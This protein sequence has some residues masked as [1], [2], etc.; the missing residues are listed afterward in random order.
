V[1]FTLK[2]TPDGIKLFSENNAHTT[3]YTDYITEIHS[4]LYIYRDSLILEP[5]EHDTILEVPLIAQ[6]ADK[7]FWAAA[8]LSVLGYQRYEDVTNCQVMEVARTLGVIVGANQNCCEDP[9]SCNETI[10]INGA[11]KLY[12]YFDLAKIR[13]DSMISV[14][15]IQRSLNVYGPIWIGTTN[16]ANAISNTLVIHGIKD[17]ILYIM[18]P[19][20]GAF[21]T[22]HY[23]EL[24]ANAYGKWAY[25]LVPRF[26]RLGGISF[27]APAQNVEYINPVQFGFN[28][29]TAMTGYQ[30]RL[31]Q[32]GAVAKDTSAETKGKTLIELAKGESYKATARG[33]KMYTA[34]YV[35]RKF[36]TWTKDTIDFTVSSTVDAN[37]DNAMHLRIYPN[38]AA[39]SL[40]ISSNLNTIAARFEM[41]DLLGNAVQSGQVNSNGNTT[42]DLS[43]QTAGTYLLI[44]RDNTNA[45]LLETEIV[46]Y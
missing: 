4:H 32:N 17:S 12:D 29:D 8:H 24:K 16:Q 28:L 38:P 33:Y 14:P 37:E 13:V 10:S 43:G 6:S 20:S 35:G 15:E 45:V 36:G 22:K 3:E 40:V 2:T 9:S 30:I 19:V 34:Q 39:E 7:S 23:K 25:T 5:Y 27:N 18:N 31:L 21:E 46:K 41:L 42:I 44:I 26:S 11:E 1:V